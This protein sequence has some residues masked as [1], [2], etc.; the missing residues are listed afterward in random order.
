MKV[1]LVYLNKRTDNQKLMNPAPLT[2]PL[3]AAYTPPDIEISIVDE[4]FETIDYDQEVD[5]VA[6]TFVLPL[7]HRAYKL[8]HEF[9]K[10]GKTIVCGGP[11]ATLMPD[12]SAVHFDSVVIGQGDLT[13]TILLDDFKKGRIKKFYTNHQ[14]IDMTTIPFSRRDLLNP[15]GY[16]ILNT[17]QATRGCPYSCTYC[18]THTIYPKFLTPPVPKVVEEIEQI[19]GGP[20]HRRLLLFWD[21]NLVGNPVWAKKLFEEMMPLKKTWVAQLTFT[22]TEDKDLVRTAA[23]SGCV[24][25]FFGLESFN[26]LSLKNSNKK[27][28]VVDKYKD[29][30]KLLHDHGI[31]VY[32]GMMFGFDD[33][34]KDIFEITLEKAIEL[35]IDNLGPKILVPYPNLPLYEKLVK[36]NRIIHT[37]W[38]KYNG[39][40]AVYHPRHMTAEELE[41]GNKWFHREFH[42]YTSIAKRLWKSKAATWFALPINLS[43]RKALYAKSNAEF[44]SAQ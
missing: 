35:G 7:A 34:R 11:H 29:G 16:S 15:K 27:H 40:H 9:R 21:D 42:S 13:W 39:N 37:D 38:S 1:L 20:F 5:L 36:E 4:A 44:A 17:F 14:D 22:I 41:Q 6:T 26:S 33:D 24:G 8:A 12:E 3:L 31:S 23:K 18:T 2:L 28:N 25:L 10:R 43:K 32:A 19:E 30:I